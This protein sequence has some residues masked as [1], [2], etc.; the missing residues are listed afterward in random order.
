ML[1]NPHF[2]IGYDNQRKNPAWVIYDL[3]GPIRFP[4]Q[5][6]TR[7]ATFATDFRT[8][9]HVAHRDYSNSGYDRGHLWP[10]YAAWSRYGS[11]AFKGTF[12]CSNMVPQLHSVNAGI[13]ETLEVEIAGRFGRGGG[14]A[15][16]Y[17]HLTV[18][19]G[20]VYDER[21]EHLR[22]GITVPAACF[23]IVLDWQEDRLGYRSLAFQIPNRE[24][25]KGPLSRYLTSIKAIE[26]ATGLDVFAGAA[27]RYRDALET[28]RASE[29]WR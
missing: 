3:D 9:A 29:L 27:S 4:G 16:K 7:P 12:I 11:E 10:A 28:A 6:P 19:N 13:W 24:G 25:T 14:W 20:P 15:E 21:P 22:T 26:D 18:I 2:T 8:S 23:S 17:G 1:E 5:E